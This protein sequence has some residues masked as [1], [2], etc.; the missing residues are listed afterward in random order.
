MSDFGAEVI[1][2]ERPPYGDPY[3]YL[4]QNVGMP[5]S[6]HSYCWIVTSRNKKSL[7]LDLAAD[8]G[9][10]VLM[11]L[12]ANADVFVTNFQQQ[13]IAKFHLSYEELRAVNERII[14][15]HVTGYGQHGEEAKRP[16]YDQTAY[17]ARSG[18]MGMMHNADAEPCRSPTGFGDYP[19][20]LSLFG[21]I[22]L[23]LYR[24]A[25]TGQGSKVTTSLMANGAW[26]NSCSLQ[27]ALCQAEFPPR[28]TRRNPLNPLVNH[29]LTRDGQRLV[30]CC[31]DQTKDWPNVCRALELD[32]EL[33]DPRFATRE[34]RAQHTE[35]L[36][37]IID[38]VIAKKDLDEW[39]ELFRKYDLVWGPVPTPQQ[40]TSDP[41]LEANGVFVNLE[42]PV[43]GHLRTVNS[44]IE[45]EGMGKRS[46]T[47]AP[48]VGEHTIEILRELGY[49]DTAIRSLL[50]QRIVSA[51]EGSGVSG[52]DPQSSD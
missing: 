36:V 10:Q 39:T 18:F 46:P 9:R 40:L 47:P 11:E 35:Q 19:T 21:G 8:A 28:T 31:V 23:G 34:S 4:S 30:M 41:Q 50:H 44:P 45:L 15:A 22:M 13:L 29:Y 1:K 20:S 2:I 32:H 14:F 52:D 17:W 37:A 12:V 26:A 33:D 5:I 24:R 27:A 3:R 43:S 49:S 51:P 48:K 38:K 6:Q 42:D 25:V 7:T 16:A